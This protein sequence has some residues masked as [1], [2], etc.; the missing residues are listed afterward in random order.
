[1]SPPEKPDRLVRR[2]RRRLSTVGEGPAIRYSIALTRNDLE[3]SFGLVYQSYVDVGLQASSPGGI[4]FVKHHLLPQTQVF[5]AERP[6]PGEL[7]GTV[8]L[9]FDTPLGLPMESVCGEA[10][11]DLRW[12]GNRLAEVVALAVAPEFRRTNLMMRLYHMVF[13]YAH[14]LGVTHLGCAVMRPHAAFYRDVL[15]FEPVGDFVPYAPGNGLEVQGHFLDL[16]TAAGKADVELREFFHSKLSWTEGKLNRLL[17]PWS[18]ETLRYF[19][20]EKSDMAAHFDEKTR[21]ILRREY[22]KTGHRFTV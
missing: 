4:R 22:A 18:P 17:T 12:Q 14:L 6:E 15:L 19:T 16:R 13:E 11:D 9:I 8:T 2:R 20:V 10:V 3:R 7:L 1:M 21:Y 5:L